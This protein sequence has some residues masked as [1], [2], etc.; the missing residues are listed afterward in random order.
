MAAKAPYSSYRR[1]TFK[2]GIVLLVLFS[3]ALAY[4][5]YLSKYE[6]SHRTEFYEKHTK[7]GKMDDTMKFNRYAPFV[8]LPVAAVLGVFLYNSRKKYLLAEENELVI[9]GNEK[10]P[11]DSIEKIDKSNYDKKGFF[12]IT[13]KKDGQEI[14]RKISYKTYDNL[15]KILEI[16]ISKIS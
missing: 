15:D 4:D 11:Y 12:I 2:L 9:D 14:D 10:I 8:F 16:L 6:W 1:N 13:Y 7:D 5:G 3:I